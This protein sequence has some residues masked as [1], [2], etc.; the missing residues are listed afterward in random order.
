M[1]TYTL[2]RTFKGQRLFA[3]FTPEEG[4]SVIVTRNDSHRRLPRW[5]ARNLYRQ[6][7]AAGYQVSA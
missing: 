7:L 3:Q 1:S 6:L 2:V 5:E 4:R